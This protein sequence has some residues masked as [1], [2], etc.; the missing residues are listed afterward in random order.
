LAG[1]TGLRKSLDETNVHRPEIFSALSHREV[2]GV[3]EVDDLVRVLIHPDGGLK[4]IP[5]DARKAALLNQ[6]DTDTDYIN[7]LRV[8]NSLLPHFDSVALT[9]LK[10]N[11]IYRVIE[12]T[13][14][15][16]LAGGESSRFGQPK[17][18][19][20][21]RGKPLIRH[22]VETALKA[23]LSPVIVVTGA[24]DEPIREALRGLDVVIR[25][26]T[27]WQAGQSTSVGE[28]IRTLPKN[29]GSA[30]FLLADQP[31]VTSE[32]IQALRQLHEKTLS[33]I[34]A[35]R[36]AGRRA[37]P[38]LFDQVTFHDLLG[39]SGDTGGRALFTQ[40]LVEYLDWSDQRL[41]FDIDTIED[42][43]RLLEDEE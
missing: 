34:I 28:G 6:V 7:G 9:S 17:M 11:L 20:E 27:Q 19:L 16:I 37:N 2:G 22:T 40:Y 36:V 4:G 18:L 35:P 1:L 41:R 23:G 25:H 10:E 31:Y 39:L 21:W 33:P 14:G 13:A 15:I 24:V 42:Y 12:P 8:A 29:I 3:I 43:H 38:V 32:V 5:P 26:N 30:L